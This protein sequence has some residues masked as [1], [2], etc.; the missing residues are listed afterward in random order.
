LLAGWLA[1]VE[2]LLTLTLSSSQFILKYI[3]IYY[4]INF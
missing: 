4:Y 1:G 2:L 3:S